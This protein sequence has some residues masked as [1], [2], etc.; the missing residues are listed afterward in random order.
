MIYRWRGQGG[1]GNIDDRPRGLIGDWLDWLVWSSID[2]VIS[3][4]GTISLMIFVLGVWFSDHSG[5]SVGTGVQS[6]LKGPHKKLIGDAV[7]EKTLESSGKTQFKTRYTVSEGTGRVYGL[8]QGCG[9]HGE[10]FIDSITH[11][12][13][14]LWTSISKDGVDSKQVQTASISKLRQ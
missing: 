4:D 6:A 14:S 13:G 3:M 1:R 12:L 5:S 2:G 7:S 11:G 10:H 8:V 9:L